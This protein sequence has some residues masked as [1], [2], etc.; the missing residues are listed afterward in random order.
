MTCPVCE[1]T[2][3]SDDHPCRFEIACLCWTGRA[4][5]GSGRGFFYELNPVVA[6]FLDEIDKEEA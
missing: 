1:R 4:C 6:S 3:E 2:A 5:D